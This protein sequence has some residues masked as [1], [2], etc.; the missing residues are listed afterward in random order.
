[1]NFAPDEIPLGDN[2]PENCIYSVPA[3]ET[4]NH[5]AKFGRPPVS[6]VGAVTKPT[7]KT[8]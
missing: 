3:Q 2:S 4:A 1:V 5:R 6:D 8:R 7:N